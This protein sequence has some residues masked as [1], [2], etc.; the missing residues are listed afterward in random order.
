MLNTGDISRSKT[1]EIASTEPHQSMIVFDSAGKESRSH[2]LMQFA[3]L[4]VAGTVSDSDG[5]KHKFHEVKVTVSD[6]NP[7]IS[8]DSG[9]ASDCN[10][11]ISTTNEFP[12]SYENVDLGGEQSVAALWEWKSNAPGPDSLTLHTYSSELTTRRVHAGADWG[13]ADLL[14][15]HLYLGLEKRFGSHDH[16]A[17]ATGTGNGA[18]A[19]DTALQCTL[20]VCVTPVKKEELSKKL[21]MGPDGRVIMPRDIADR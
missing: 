13:G 15:N 6:L 5:I 17:K 8:E 7:S 1:I 20:E 16:L 18:G 4:S 11:Y 3:R 14:V 2:S 9:V 19:G 21:G 10:V 12:T